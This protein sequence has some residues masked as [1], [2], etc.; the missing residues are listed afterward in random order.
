MY[1]YMAFALCSTADELLL[2]KTSITRLFTS[3]KYQ[4]VFALDGLWR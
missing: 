2:I 3:Y 1:K 4:L